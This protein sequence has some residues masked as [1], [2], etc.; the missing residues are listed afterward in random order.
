V[1]NN[2]AKMLKMRY[3]W[4]DGSEAD[5]ISHGCSAHYTNLLSRDVDMSAV[6]GHHFIVQA[7]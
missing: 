1:T 7:I 3:N 2:A 4:A 5:I 6:K